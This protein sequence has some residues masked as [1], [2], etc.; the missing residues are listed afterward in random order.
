MSLKE[1][2]ECDLRPAN[3]TLHRGDEGIGTIQTLLHNENYHQTTK[4]ECG[5]QL[6]SGGVHSGMSIISQSVST[7]SC[8]RK[9]SQ[10]ERTHV[11][12][13]QYRRNSSCRRKHIY[14]SYAIKGIYSMKIYPAC[15]GLRNQS[16]LD[17]KPGSKALE[18][19]FRGT[20]PRE[21]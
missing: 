3:P 15:P 6:E 11:F 1:R 9:P 7:K 17:E 18:I 20:S 12:E 19:L 2:V 8:L 21:L 5:N 13:E 10:H 16:V 14:C 4:S